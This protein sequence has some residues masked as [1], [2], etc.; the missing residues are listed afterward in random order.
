MSKR[1]YQATVHIYIGKKD[2]DIADWLNMLDRHGV[3]KARWLSA[4]LIAYDKGT[5]IPIG[6]VTTRLQTSN[7]PIPNASKIKVCQSPKRHSASDNMIFG[8]NAYQE[9]SRVAIK[10]NRAAQNKPLDIHSHLYVTISNKNAVDIYKK[11]KQEGYFVATVLKYTIRQCLETGEGET[12][13]DDVIAEQLLSPVI[14]KPLKRVSF[15]KY[16]ETPEIAASA[17]SHEDTLPSENRVSG[18]KNRVKNPLLDF[19]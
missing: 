19:I 3:N 12:V 6:S 17:M 9:S 15:Q 7:T 18:P 8:I 11:L 5:T 10:G 2:Q 1:R 16:I 4:L 13:P 14:L